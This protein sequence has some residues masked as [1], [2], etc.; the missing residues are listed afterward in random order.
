MF[1][2]IYNIHELYIYIYIYIFVCVCVC[3]CVCVWHQLIDS[4]DIR[5]AQRP[6]N[7]LHFV[8]YTHVPADIKQIPFVFAPKLKIT[9][10][11]C[12]NNN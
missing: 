12:P 4:R 10:K 5:K 6:T 1:E 2:V 7:W 9:S 3:V 8:R 11:L